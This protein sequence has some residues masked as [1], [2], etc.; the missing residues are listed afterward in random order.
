M[1]VTYLKSCSTYS[2]GKGVNV[3]RINFR[4]GLI[5]DSLLNYFT[6]Q[7]SVE[8]MVFWCFGIKINFDI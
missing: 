3:F 4:F 7:L 1:S 2:Y 6:Y 8:F 5:S